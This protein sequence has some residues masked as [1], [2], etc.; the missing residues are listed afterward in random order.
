ML[1][2]IGSTSHCLFVADLPTYPWGI[3]FRVGLED[4]FPAILMPPIIA[5]AESKSTLRT[6]QKMGQRSGDP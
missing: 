4:E 6:V 1:L 5:A 3:R 2:K